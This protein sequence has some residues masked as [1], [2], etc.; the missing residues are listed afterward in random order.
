MLV[1]KRYVVQI[2]AAVTAATAGGFIEVE[3]PYE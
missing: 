3:I 2:A 1:I